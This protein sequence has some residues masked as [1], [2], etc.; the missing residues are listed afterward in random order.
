MSNA[1]LGAH[2]GLN[3]VA[4]PVF[5]GSELSS[6]NARF[7]IILVILVECMVF[8]GLLS[9]YMVFKFNNL[10]TW[11]PEGLPKYP[12]ERTLLNTALLLLSGVTMYLFKA[13]L[14]DPLRLVGCTPFILIDSTLILGL[15]FLVLQGY[16]WARLIS[17]GLTL[18]SSIYGGIFYV[19]IGFH[20][21][22]VLCA[23]IWLLIAAVISYVR[24]FSGCMVMLDIC[25]TFWY[26]VVLLWPLIYAVVYL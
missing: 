16:E 18:S 23:V 12:A 21:I 10:A 17:H 15:A 2:D 6:R 14:S 20:A 19:I 26:F 13:R 9:A 3:A 4:G 1:A 25:G 8:A 11:P 24:K 22:H 5:D 7:A